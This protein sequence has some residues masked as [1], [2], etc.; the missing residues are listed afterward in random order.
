MYKATIPITCDWA[1]DCVTIGRESFTLEQLKFEDEP[2]RQLVK[3]CLD[4]TEIAQIR[5]AFPEWYNEL[6]EVKNTTNDLI[7]ALKNPQ[8]HKARPNLSQSFNF[9]D[10]KRN[11]WDNRTK[12]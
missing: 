10:Y 12:P 1:N 4:E 2:L 8:T 11:L 7:E 6:F 9:K 3:D 5:L